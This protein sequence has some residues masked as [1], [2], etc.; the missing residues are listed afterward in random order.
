MTADP[1]PVP[2]SPR[3]TVPLGSPLPDRIEEEGFA[4]ERWRVDDEPTLRAIVAASLDHLRPFLGWAHLEP[5]SVD[6]RVALLTR[7]EQAWRDA[8]AASY[9][10]PDDDGVACGTVSMFRDAGPQT[11]EIGYWITPGASGRG[12]VTRAARLLTC[13]AFQYPEVDTVLIGHDAANVRSGAVPARLGFRRVRARTRKPE[14]PACV[15]I[16]VH[17]EAGRWWRAPGASA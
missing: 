2:P 8:Y 4:L 5:I 13:A 7:W 17:L 11:L 14:A 12:R 16:S 15:G 1:P 9:K 3:Y 10:I 6:D